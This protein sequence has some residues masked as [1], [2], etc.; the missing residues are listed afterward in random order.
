MTTKLDYLSE[1]LKA[2][3]SRL[4]DLRH[5]GLVLTGDELEGFIKRFDYFAEM[6]I[7][8]ET[9]LSAVEWNRRAVVERAELLTPNAIVMLEAMRPE[10]NVVYFRRPETPPP[11][12]GGDAA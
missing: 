5:G 10:S 6:A 8:L 11:F 1:H 12:N 3:R 9:A 4:A 2:T 7:A